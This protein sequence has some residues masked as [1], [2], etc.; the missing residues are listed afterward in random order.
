MRCPALYFLAFFMTL[1]VVA[2]FTASAHAQTGAT[3]STPTAN[4]SGQLA[5]DPL[6]QAPDEPPPAAAD[7]KLLPQINIEKEKGAEQHGDAEDIMNLVASLPQGVREVIMQE[8]QNSIWFCE[9]NDMLLNFYNCNCFSLKVAAERIKKG[10]DISFAELVQKGDFKE[11][12][13][14]GLIA[15]YG[16]NRCQDSLGFSPATTDQLNNICE[17]AGRALAQNFVRQPL[18]NIIFV[19]HLFNDIVGGCRQMYGF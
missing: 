5:P 1:G 16:M 9:H 10:P 11:C 3:A 7:G 18:P 15:G 13:D 2:L 19:N 6:M 4:G 14:M 12:V 8:A 17:C